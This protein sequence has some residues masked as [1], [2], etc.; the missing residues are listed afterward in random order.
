MALGIKVKA[1]PEDWN[2]PVRNIGNSSVNTVI[3]K[4][5]GWGLLL[6]N[7]NLAN[8]VVA[9]ATG[10]PYLANFSDNFE[11]NTTTRVF[12]LS[13]AFFTW[14]GTDYMNRA[15]VDSAFAAMEVDIAAIETT[16]GPVGATGSQGIQGPKGDTG[17]TGPQG[18]QGTQGIKGDKG[19]TGDTGP[20]GIQGVKGDTGLTG[21]TGSQGPIGVTGSVG[22]TGPKGDQGDAGSTGATGIQGPQGIQGPIGLTGPAGA[23]AANPA[24]LVGTVTVSETAAIALTA[25]VRKVTV[26]ATGAVVGGN[27]LLF[28]TGATPANYALADVVCVT[29]NQLQVSVTAP[30]LA[31]GASYSIPCRL[32]KINTP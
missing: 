12:D 7:P 30:L 28:P 16:P 9:G 13:P 27:Y 18:I 1:A 29:A 31:L 17:N 26:S 6:N 32:V 22:A 4:I 10:S 23:A 15:D 5:T 3:P 20:Q 14:L 21:A 11:C 25:G 19:D 2:I 8:P 24:T